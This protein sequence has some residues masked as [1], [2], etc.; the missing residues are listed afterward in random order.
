MVSGRNELVRP[1]RPTGMHRIVL[2]LATTAGGVAM[3]FG[4]HTSTMGPGAGAT[5]S[6]LSGAGALTP[7]TSGGSSGSGDS[8]T[9]DSASGS[10]GSTG[11]DAA[12]TYTGDSVS[13]EWGPV[14]VQIAV[15]NGRITAAS[16]VQYPNG[17]PRDQEINAFALPVL[18]QEAVAAQSAQ[19][20]MVSG[21]TVTSQGYLTSLQ[22]AIDKAHL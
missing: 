21:A 15:T 6:A 19:I 8:S 4:Y 20:D 22:S 18:A 12:T 1:T 11:A 3:L 2:A 17:N 16:A 14:Q 7:S 10:S 13:T 5:A 9:S